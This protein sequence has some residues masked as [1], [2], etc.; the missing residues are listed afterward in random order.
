MKLKLDLSIA[1]V[2]L[3]LCEQMLISYSVSNPGL[4]NLYNYNRLLEAD[5]RLH[6]IL[7]IY[8]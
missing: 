5:H 2:N 1:S 7:N 4:D 8:F 3:T 6:M